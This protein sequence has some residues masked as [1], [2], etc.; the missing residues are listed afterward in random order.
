[1]AVIAVVGL[2]LGFP[3][4][5]S[6][7]V[8]TTLNPSL[9]GDL[10]G[11]YG[12]PNDPGPLN[13]AN[14][15]LRTGHN[16]G[17]TGGYKSF[18]KFDLSSLPAMPILTATARFYL[19]SGG[20]WGGNTIVSKVVDP[21]TA[22]STDY[23]LTGSDLA[24]IAQ[25]ADGATPS[26][27]WYSV[28]L[29]SVARDW[30]SDPATNYG[31]ALRHNYDGCCTGVFGNFTSSE[32]TSAHRPE[33]VIV[34]APYGLVL[35]PSLDL[36]VTP[37]NVPSYD[38]EPGDDYNTNTA[39]D[40]RNDTTQLFVG[41]NDTDSAGDHRSFVKFDLPSS[42][43]SVELVSATL[44]FHLDS[45]QPYGGT[46][47]YALSSDWNGTSV[48]YSQSVSTNLGV[49][50]TVSDPAGQYYELSN[51][52]LLATVA[53]WAADPATNFGVRLTQS[54]GYT[55]TLDVFSSLTG[56]HPPELVLEFAPI[57]IPEPS[58]LV[59]WCLLAGLGIGVG[60]WRKR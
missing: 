22:A 46:R 53:S 7:A 55:F 11:T 51:P 15:Q 35:N 26:P 17:W 23:D 25:H 57:V 20:P 41:R 19:E 48:A 27:G 50:V 3:T 45:T 8:T 30:Q 6:G 37:N 38:G 12:G 44:R 10:L 4:A 52:A 14:A 2:L 5:G 58:T 18:V 9:D 28:D 31:L 36:Y 40:S 60:W 21:W 13:T 1:M 16:N 42:L 24:Q 49:L 33:L 56:G 43:G 34:Q 59:I 54:E 39:N 47:V 32:G 29:G